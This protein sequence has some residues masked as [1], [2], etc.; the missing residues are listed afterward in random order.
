[1]MSIRYKHSAYYLYLK[2]M[3]YDEHDI[4][5]VGVKSIAH[6]YIIVYY[7]IS[8]QD[9]THRLKISYD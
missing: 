3:V 4:A 2:F 9:L 5:C 1:M 8:S 7:R 6:L